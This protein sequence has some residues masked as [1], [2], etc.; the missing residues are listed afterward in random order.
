MKKAKKSYFKS[1]TKNFTY[2]KNTK[3]PRRAIS[4]KNS[5]ANINPFNFRYSN[6]NLKKILLIQRNWKIHYRKNIENKIIKIQSLIRGNIIRDNFNEVF[7]MNKK[8]E[9]FF[10]IIKITMFRHAINYDYLASKR[11]DYYSDHKNTKY[12]LLLQRRIR[13]FL[14]IKKIKVFE[15]LGI[16]N[17]I[18]IITK[19]YRTKIKSKMTSDKYLAKPIFKFHR[20]LIQIKM[21]QRNY[22]IHAK[23]MRKIN[24]QK[25]DKLFL[26]KSP[27][28]TK[29]QRYII[30]K[31][32]DNY[33]NVKNK[34]INIKKDFY[35]KVNYN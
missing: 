11:I 15:K 30:E 1:D 32:E 8:L 7:I 27:L 14:F 17:N 4:K 35:T 3:S 33:K 20:P 13:Y 28:I 34:V 25:I 16:F 21:I 26:N 2:T 12:F 31:E 10:F 19:E 24:K 6:T 29:E 23:L 22:L 9:M 5:K 18:Y